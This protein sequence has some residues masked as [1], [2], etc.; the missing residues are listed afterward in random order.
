[1]Q[2]NEESVIKTL[3]AISGQAKRPFSEQSLNIQAD[4]PG[5]NGHTDLDL[6]ALSLIDS[7]RM[8]QF[9]HDLFAEMCFKEGTSVAS[10]LVF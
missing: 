1:M 3:Q 5:W 6:K 7:S 10:E 9:Y 4:V 8:L 2:A